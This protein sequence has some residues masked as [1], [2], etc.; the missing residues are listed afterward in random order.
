MFNPS[1]IIL[2]GRWVILA[3]RVNVS[4]RKCTWKIDQTTW[5]SFLPS[6]IKIDRCNIIYKNKFSPNSL[7][8]DLAMINIL[9]MIIILISMM[10]KRTTNTLHSTFIHFDF[11]QQP[12]SWRA[13]E[14]TTKS[15]CESNQ[16][17]FW[18]REETKT[19][20]CEKKKNKEK[21]K[22]TRSNVWL[23]RKINTRLCV[24]FYLC[25]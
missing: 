24:L 14:L 15:R 13:R 1:I 5:R 11:E 20:A 8:I 12:P 6:A 25:V 10:K 22:Q 19:N 21:R 17:S 4:Y 18:S 7:L 23:Y 9:T 2:L 16:P 3:L